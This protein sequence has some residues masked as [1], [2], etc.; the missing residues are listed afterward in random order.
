MTDVEKVAA[1]PDAAVEAAEA[2]FYGTHERGF[3]RKPLMTA[4]DMRAAI[5]AALAAMAGEA[6][7]VG[8]INFLLLEHLKEGH[9]AR[10]VF[11]SSERNVIYTEPLYA[12]PPAARADR[13][14]V[15][16]DVTPEMIAAG[17]AVI[18]DGREW[19]F[20]RV[21]AGPELVE[22]YKA[23]RAAAIRKLKETT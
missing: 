2:A 4:G 16:E 12:H 8:Y 21:G 10:N 20:K 13:D 11:V 22:V 5:S 9:D 19:P 14:A 18:N 3:V 15:V 7:P 23:M 6:E 17:W 1:I